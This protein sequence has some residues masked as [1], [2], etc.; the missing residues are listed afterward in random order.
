[1]SFQPGKCRYRVA[2]T[3]GISP[4]LTTIDHASAMSVT[5]FIASP[6][7]YSERRIDRS[8][9]VGNLKVKTCSPAEVVVTQRFTS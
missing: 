1:V 6:T 5:L 3:C 4:C 8:W 9:T 2:T 7:T